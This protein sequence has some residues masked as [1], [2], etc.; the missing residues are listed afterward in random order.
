[1]GFHGDT[2]AMKQHFLSDSLNFMDKPTCATCQYFTRPGVPGTAYGVCVRFPIGVDH[3]QE[4][5]CGEH[6]ER[7]A[8]QFKEPFLELGQLKSDIRNVEAPLI[9]LA[10]STKR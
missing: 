9:K 2:V 1:M 7:G 3:N 10:K 5:W 4:H 8:A 6:K